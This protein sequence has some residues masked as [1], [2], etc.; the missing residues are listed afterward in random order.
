MSE[1]K[2]IQTLPPVEE[3]QPRTPLSPR[4]GE[5]V[6]PPLAFV[7]AGASYLAVAAVM[8]VYAL[9]WWHAAHPATYPSSARLI[10]WV[11]PDPGKW[12]SLTL[13]GALA[14]G[15]VLAAGAVGIAGFQAWNGWLWSRW[16]GL[17]ALLL[18]GGFAAITSDWAYVA[19]GL[20]L[21]VAVT[22]WLPPMTRYLRQ[23]REVRSARPDSYR[24]P[25]LIHYGRLPR[26]R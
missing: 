20:T 21:I 11:A 1:P 9:H 3:L 26:F 22:I 8:A 18:M 7:A 14:G 5:P 16:A 10:G 6:R 23:W 15:A 17:V 24:R 19:V 2:Q 13:E 12:L 4:T 25:D